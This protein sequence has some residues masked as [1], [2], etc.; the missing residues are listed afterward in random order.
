MRKSKVLFSG[1]G[2]IF[3]CAGLALIG[4]RA[5]DA[6]PNVVPEILMNAAKTYGITKSGVPPWRLRFEFQTYEDAGETPRSGTFEEAWKSADLRMER[7]GGP[8]SPQSIYWTANGVF[9]TGNSGPIPF[10]QDLL[11]NEIVNPMMSPEFLDH[12]AASPDRSILVE[13]RAVD[14]DSVRCFRLQV[15]ARDS[16]APDPRFISDYCFA[17]DG[18]LRLYTAGTPVA[19][20]AS[21]SNFINFQGHLIPKDVKLKLEGKV[22]ATAHVDGIE[23]LGSSDEAELQPPPNARPWAPF[24]PPGPTSGIVGAPAANSNPVTEMTQRTR[25]LAAPPRKINISAGVA[26]GMLESKVDPVY[27]EEARAARVSGTVVLQATINT[28]GMV[29]E[30]R[31]VSGPAMLQQAALDAV[32]QWRYRPYLLNSTPVQVQTTVNVIFSMSE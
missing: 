19:S 7:Y 16:G 14:G 29:E 21:F 5:Q 13:D 12:F 1:F 9:Q 20:E 25:V 23:E 3:A 17:S 28:Q 32:K 10:A 6:A 2:V 4:L 8:L 18:S 26:V 11:R 24:P 30:V 22:I 31:V 27:P 15:K